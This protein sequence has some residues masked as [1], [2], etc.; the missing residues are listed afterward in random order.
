MPRLK[1]LKINIPRRKFVFIV[2]SA[3]LWAVIDFIWVY[4]P[5]FSF[6][7]QA[8]SWFIASTFTGLEFSVLLFE[9]DYLDKKL[10][11]FI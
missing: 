6:Y 10:T 5:I 3:I 9:W 1:P 2:A 11:S 8:V 7:P 4:P